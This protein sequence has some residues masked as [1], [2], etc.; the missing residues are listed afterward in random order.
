MGESSPLFF[1]FIIMPEVTLGESRVLVTYKN[2]ETQ[3]QTD[4]SKIRKLSAELIDFINEHKMA[5]TTPVGGE[6]ARVYAHAMTVIEDAC[7][8]SIKAICK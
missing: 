8:W 4:I 1:T 5:R 6:E 7:M 3:Q 2:D